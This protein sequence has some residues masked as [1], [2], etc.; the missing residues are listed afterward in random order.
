MPM[1]GIEFGPHRRRSGMR[2]MTASFL[3]TGLAV[4]LLVTASRSEE[5]PRSQ[6]V[7]LN[8]NTAD[9]Q[10]ERLP[11]LVAW[12]SDRITAA[13]QSDELDIHGDAEVPDMRMKI[14]VDIRRNTDRPG[15]QIRAAARCV[16]R[17]GHC[18]AGHPNEVLGECARHST[19]RRVDQDHRGF[20]LVR[21]SG[22]K[23]DRERNLQS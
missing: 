8:E 5:A 9:S 22:R 13:G 15:S 23:T 20:V 3:A 14:I 16:R 21:A 7:V 10:D 19:Y 17:Q 6:A 4:T 18:R 1:I 12:R 11:G 2:R